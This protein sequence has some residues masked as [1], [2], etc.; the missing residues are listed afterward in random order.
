MH[1]TESQD[2]IDAIL[3]SV[4]NLVGWIEITNHRLIKHRRIRF[5]IWFQTLTCAGQNQ[6]TVITK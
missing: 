2:D 6:F 4:I 5:P 3:R 1:V